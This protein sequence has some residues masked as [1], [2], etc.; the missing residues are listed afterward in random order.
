MMTV[1]DASFLRRFQPRYFNLKVL[2]QVSGSLATAF[3]RTVASSG[4]ISITIGTET[5]TVTET[6]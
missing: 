1:M 6:N 2:R 4:I 3:G 5:E